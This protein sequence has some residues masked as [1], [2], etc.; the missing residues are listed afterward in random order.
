MLVALLD[1]T[2]VAEKVAMMAFQMV[3]GK[4]DLKGEPKV[5]EKVEKWVKR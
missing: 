2:M 1:E 3:V 5:C 4:V